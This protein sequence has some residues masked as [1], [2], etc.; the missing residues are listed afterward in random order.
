MCPEKMEEQQ[1]ARRDLATPDQTGPHSEIDF[2]D[3]DLLWVQSE[4]KAL[5]MWETLPV[6]IGLAAS[7]LVK[8]WLSQVSPDS[9]GRENSGL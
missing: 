1:I 5:Q 8:L 2:G 3:Q 4:A 7:P 9:R 6:G